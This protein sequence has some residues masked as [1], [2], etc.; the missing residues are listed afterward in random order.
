MRAGEGQPGQS[1]RTSNSTSYAPTPRPA[2]IEIFAVV[3]GIVGA[4]PRP[5]VAMTSQA[6]LQCTRS[7]VGEPA[8]GTRTMIGTEQTEASQGTSPLYRPRLLRR[9]KAALH[10]GHVLI[11]APPGYGKTTLLRS[12]LAERPHTRY[13]P[14]SAADA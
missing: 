11:S 1:P 5:W 7:G 9:L 6:I 14:L 3:G 13:L 12:L 10:A 4:L 8:T 2:V